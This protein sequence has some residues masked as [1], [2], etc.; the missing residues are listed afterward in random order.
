MKTTLEIP[1]A[2]FRQAKAAT[3]EQGIPLRELVTVALAEKL[4]GQAN[5]QKPWM[6]SF[7]KLRSLHAETEEL[8]LPVI[9]LGEYRYG[10]NQSRHRLRYQQW[11]AELISVSRILDVDRLTADSSASP[12]SVAIITAMPSPDSAA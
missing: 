1:D 8:V 12:S 6:N 11:L 2:L 4:R 10:I 5:A 3:A 9:V 7:G